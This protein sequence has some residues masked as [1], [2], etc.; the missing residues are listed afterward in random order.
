[1]QYD[2]NI[3]NAEYRICEPRVRRILEKQAKKHDNVFLIFRTRYFSQDGS[4]RYLV[5][6]FYEVEKNFNK[7]QREAPIIYAKAMHFVSLSNCIDVTD[8][9]KEEG[10]FRCCFTSDCLKW[11]KE[12]SNWYVKL[13]GAPNYT[14]RYIEETNNLKRVFF[15]NEKQGKNYQICASCEYNR[16]PKSGCPLSWRRNCRSMTPH[17]ANYMKNL[18]EYFESIMPKDQKPVT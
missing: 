9:I 13:G 7:T 4:S 18:D 12:L 10:A 8:K 3:E 2:P 5:T 6:G 15:E 11:N 1:M 14:D 16:S 17:P